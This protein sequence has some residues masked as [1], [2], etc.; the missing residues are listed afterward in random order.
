MVTHGPA[1]DLEPG[2][3]SLAPHVDELVVIANLRGA[4]PGGVPEST[5]KIVN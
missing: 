3:A 5:R 1:P 4:R 2:L